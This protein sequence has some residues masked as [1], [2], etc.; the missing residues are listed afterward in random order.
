MDGMVSTH[1]LLSGESSR[2]EDTMKVA[3]LCL[4]ASSLDHLEAYF[5]LQRPRQ[6]VV[7]DAS[8]TTYLLS[9]NPVSL[10]SVLSPIY[11][12]TTIFQHRIDK[13]NQKRNKKP[14]K[15]HGSSLAGHVD[16]QLHH[17]HE[18]RLF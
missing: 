18:R 10:G 9:F 8:H 11:F 13:T 14:V 17:I 5:P 6:G 1:S 15:V 3:T 4:P 7:Q 16:Y 12:L 2:G